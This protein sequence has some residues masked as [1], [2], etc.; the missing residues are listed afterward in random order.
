[1]PALKPIKLIRSYLAIAV[2]YGVLGLFDSI[3][4][5]VA[6]P[7]RAYL[8]A[9]FLIAVLFLL[10]N[11]AALAVFIARK[12]PWI[13]L[14]LPVYHV[15]LFLALLL[16]SVFGV[17]IP[18]QFLAFLGGLTSVAEIILAGY[19][20]LGVSHSRVAPS[21]TAPSGTAQLKAAA[22]AISHK[23]RSAPRKS[24]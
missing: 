13:F 2:A 12:V 8:G 4:A 20:L 3:L 24:R 6:V 17:G 19:L 9:V 23:P 5:F 22:P 1:M 18:G 10:L 21:G 11:V 14:I 15:A 16:L 7:G